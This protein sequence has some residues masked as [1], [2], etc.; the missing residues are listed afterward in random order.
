MADENIE[1][2]NPARLNVQI[3]ELVARS[4]LIVSAT[5]LLSPVP[6]DRHPCHPSI[7]SSFT[8]S[9][10]QLELVLSFFDSLNISISFE[11]RYDFLVSVYRIC[12]E[13]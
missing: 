1:Y 8:S 9:P 3:R 5:F 10:L 12:L 2:F 6:R 11:T 7:S 13:H 4:E